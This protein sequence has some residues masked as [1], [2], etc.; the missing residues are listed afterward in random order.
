MNSGNLRICVI[1]SVFARAEG[2]PA[3][4]FLVEQIKHLQRLGHKISVF[5]PSFRGLKSHHVYGIDVH[6]FRYFFKRWEDLTHDSGAPNKIRN[7][8][9]IFIA[10][11]YIFFG[12]IAVARLSRKENWD[13]IH[14][15]WPFPHGIFGYIAKKLCNAPMISTFHGAE[16]LLSQKF[17]FVKLFLRHAVHNSEAVTS[18]SS[19]TA[20]E[21]K[22]LI[23][24]DVSVIP[25]GVTIST[26]ANDG[27][28]GE[29]KY[30]LFAGRLIKRKGV[31]YLIEAM[32]DVTRAFNIKLYIVGDGVEKH[33]LEE[34]VKE[35]GLQDSILF[36]GIVSNETLGNLYSNCIAFVLPAIVDDRGDTEG[37]GIVLIEALMYKRPVI[38]SSVGGIVDIVQN[39]QTGLLVPEKDSAALKEAITKILREPELGNN[40]GKMGAEFVEKNFNWNEIAKK[41]DALY[42]SCT[43]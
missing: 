28:N 19:F 2:D 18:N 43:L 16:L 42:R 22:K 17:S 38:A 4:S 39:N 15:N 35:L 9:Y 32:K 3:A 7:P 31:I 27:S 1:S 23:D 8:L 41:V 14:V 30:I 20:S 29:E 26:V 36:L 5:A 34:R 37:L 12:S 25:Y 10:F 11:F 6:R 33:G 13:V 24:T 21:L 40:L